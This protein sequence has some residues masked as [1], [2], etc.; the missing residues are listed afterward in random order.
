M[1]LSNWYSWQHFDIATHYK[2]LPCLITEKLSVEFKSHVEHIETYQK[3]FW[4]VLSRQK[5]I[6]N[7][8]YLYSWPN[9]NKRETILLTFQHHGKHL[10]NSPRSEILSYPKR[11][12]QWHLRH[13]QK[14][15]NWWP[16]LSPCRKNASPSTEFHRNTYNILIL[17]N[18][19]V[20][21]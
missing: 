7:L 20:P 16:N 1:L 18:A 12:K 6:G 2:S 21:A 17:R 15:W 10:S 9:Y 11:K 14:K 5:N 13:W 4:R 19:N 3:N 8:L